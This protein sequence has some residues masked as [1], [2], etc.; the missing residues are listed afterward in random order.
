MSILATIGTVITYLKW[1][2]QVVGK[3]VGFFFERNKK[4]KEKKRKIL[5]SMKDAIKKGDTSRISI[6]FERINRL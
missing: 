4:K 1:L 5:R 6:L 2:F 3:V